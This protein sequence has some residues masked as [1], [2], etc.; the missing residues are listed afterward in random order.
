MHFKG[1]FSVPQTH[2]TAKF[3]VGF[4]IDVNNDRRMANPDAVF[5]H[6]Q[7]SVFKFFK[8]YVNVK[9]QRIKHKNTE[10]SPTD[11]SVLTVEPDNTGRFAQI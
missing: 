3:A 2:G 8:R 5:D 4:N 10:K 1:R 9:V 6:R 7:S 11:K